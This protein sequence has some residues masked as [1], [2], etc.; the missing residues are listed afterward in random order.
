MKDTDNEMEGYYCLLIAI[1]CDLNAAEAWKVYKYGMNHPLS[2]KIMSRK[3][4]LTEEEKKDKKGMPERM[5][6]L[7]TQGYSMNAIAEAYG[8]FPSAVRRRMKKE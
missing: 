6:R 1:F 5:R 3:V 7:R 2:K 4:H 8:C